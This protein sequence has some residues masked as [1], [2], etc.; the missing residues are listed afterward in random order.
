MKL[1]IFFIFIQS[2]NLSYSQD[3][4]SQVLSRSAKSSKN[5]KSILLKKYKK[6][7]KIDLGD[8]NLSGE[9]I[10]PGDI[11]IKNSKRKKFDTDFYERKNFDDIIKEEIL[12]L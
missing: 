2:I 7:E 10:S 12:K 6:Y 5:Q 11:T 1:F 9:L 3:R 4:T 8:I